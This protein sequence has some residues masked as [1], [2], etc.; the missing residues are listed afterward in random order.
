MELS[1]ATAGEIITISSTASPEPQIV[2]I[3]S[4]SIYPTILYGYGRQQLKILHSLTDL[5]LPANTF[6]ILGLVPRA[7]VPPSAEQHNNKESPQL[8]VVSEISSI[9]T[10][11]MEN[12]PVDIWETTPDMGKFCSDEL[13][14]VSILSISSTSTTQR[15]EKKDHPMNVLSKKRRVLQHIYKACGQV[16]PKGRNIRGSSRH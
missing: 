6:K 8:P 10:A 2:T 9:S 15:A 11:S 3:Q 14:G 5:N 12:S 1:G 7:L 13:R 16:L 4:D